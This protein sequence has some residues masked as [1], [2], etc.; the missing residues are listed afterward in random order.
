MACAAAGLHRQLL[1]GT[2]NGFRFFPAMRPSSRTIFS[3]LATASIA[4]F[5]WRFT[6][7]S[8][9][10]YFSPD[11]CMN[12]YRS[13]ANP[14]SALAKANLL[15][16]LNSV[17]FRPFVSVWYRCIYYF[18]GFNPVPF[19][20]SIL[21]VLAANIWLTYAV[22]RRLTGS[23]EIG[24][25]AA[26][27][28]SYHP[29]FIR[30]YFDTGYAY[31]VICYFFYFAALL[32]YLRVRQQSRPFRVWEWV[33][34]FSLYICALNSK[35]LAVTLPVFMGIYELLY[36]SIPLR[37]VREVLRWLGREG[38]PLVAAVLVTLVFVLGRG[39]DKRYSLL[40]IGPYQPVFTWARFM[41][42]SR[43]FLNNLLI[44]RHPEVSDGLLLALWLA[45]LAIAWITRSR[46]LRFAWLFVMLSPIPVAFIFPRGPAQYYIPLFG[47]VLYTATVLVRG[48]A[49]LWR[50]LPGPRTRIVPALRAPVLF[51]IIVLLLLHYYRRP[52]VNEL[53]WQTLEPDLDQSI[54]QQL[55]LLRPQLQHGSQVIFLDDPFPPDD[56]YR[57]IYL[58]RLSYHDPS[59]LVSR[60]KTMP[61]PPG[62]QEIASYD[63][64]FDYRFGRF[65][66]SVQP[67][68]QGLEP[69]LTF[70]WGQPAVFH[71]GDF[72]RVTRRHPAHPGEVVI[73]QAKDLGE[74]K[75]SV[76]VGQA[77]P[78]DPLLDVV[79]PVRVRVGGQTV[80]VI[81]KMGWPELVNTFRIDF[82]IPNSVRPGEVAV[83]ITA[84]NVTGPR[85]TIPVQ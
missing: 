58:A 81:R 21:M 60:T 82:C 24:A 43:T 15:F 37:P 19:H 46:P 16:F 38:K 14:L 45:M 80:D 84:S 33:A 73:A 39:L 62:S 53:A 28:V 6:A 17:F 25:V 54:V 63:Y 27:L 23:R 70:E 32:L 79:S 76:P 40:A 75:P 57:M 31:D 55:H 8:L 69:V 13:W 74:T 1:S 22:C 48:T 34:F 66:T 36:S 35:E 77:F 20:V 41:E 9:D 26:L 2:L 30:L 83:E 71:Y 12:L 10:Q 47:W 29:K 3:V 7:P 85:V 67:R 44:A 56:G 72:T 42:T 18:A 51:V 52:S 50:W 5:F 49:Y 11:D 4:A 61:R 59:L 68:P 65:F 78:K 64:V